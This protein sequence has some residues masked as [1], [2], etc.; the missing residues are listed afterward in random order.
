MHQALPRSL[1]GEWGWL[2][3]HG[4]SQ[5]FLALTP[6]MGQLGTTSNSGQAAT[7]ALAAA[8]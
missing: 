8:C 2:L 1:I 7:T 3:Q 5:G 6:W 4:L